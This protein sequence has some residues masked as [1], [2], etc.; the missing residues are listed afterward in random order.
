MYR[1]RSCASDYAFYAMSKIN[2]LLKFNR[3]RKPLR[4]SYKELYDIKCILLDV[5]LY[6]DG[7]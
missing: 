4:G 2:M 3:N 7:I 6:R 5:K 1:S